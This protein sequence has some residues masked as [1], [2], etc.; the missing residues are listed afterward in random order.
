MGGKLAGSSVEVLGGEEVTVLTV[1]Q[2][3][4]RV[5][6]GFGDTHVLL[7][8]PVQQIRVALETGY[9]GRVPQY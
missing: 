7:R 3:R 6:Q 9:L 8:R 4:V 1:G 2:G 5:E